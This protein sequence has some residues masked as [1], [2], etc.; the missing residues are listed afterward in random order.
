METGSPFNRLAERCRRLLECL[1]QQPLREPDLLLR[2]QLAFQRS[3]IDAARQQLARV[4]WAAS[5]RESSE[6]YSLLL[7]LNSALN[8]FKQRLVALVPASA[9]ISRFDSFKAWLASPTTGEEGQQEETT[10]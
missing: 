5:T 8:T 6:V 3:N 10:A 7:D 1:E 2:V 9:H 4:V